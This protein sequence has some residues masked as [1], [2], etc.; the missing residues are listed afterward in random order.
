MPVHEKP[1][2]PA[3]Q[4]LTIG[5]LDLPI[6]AHCPWVYISL[7]APD[8]SELPPDAIRFPAIVDTGNSLALS[9]RQLHLETLSALRLDDLIQQPGPV[10][11]IHDASGKTATIPRRKAKVWLHPFPES[12]EATARDLQVVGGILVYPTP[13]GGQQPAAPVGP[14]V[15]L[16]G[17]RAF[18]PT[19]LCVSVDYGRLVVSVRAQPQPPVTP[20]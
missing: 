10:G 17:A 11:T 1:L 6:V 18:F 19:G 2:H 14:R 5:G 12:G 16:L 4:T 7:T 20:A 8:A 15:P 3:F 13:Q 9:I